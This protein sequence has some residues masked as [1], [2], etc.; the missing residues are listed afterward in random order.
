MITELRTAMN[1]GAPNPWVL[2]VKL[3]SG[4]VYGC[5]LEGETIGIRSAAMIPRNSFTTLLKMQR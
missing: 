5:V 4:L 2:S 3:V 1:V